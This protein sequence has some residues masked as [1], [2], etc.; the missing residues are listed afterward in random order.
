MTSAGGGWTL[1]A[2]VHENNIKGKCTLGDNWSSDQGRTS[3]NY[4][5]KMVWLKRRKFHSINCQYQTKLI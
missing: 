2:S 1:V 3:N 4:N 5:G